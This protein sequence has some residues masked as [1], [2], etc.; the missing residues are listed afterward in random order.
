MT[1]LEQLKIQWQAKRANYSQS[2]QQTEGAILIAERRL[3]EA[4]SHL[5]DM[6]EARAAAQTGLQV[7]DEVLLDLAKHKSPEVP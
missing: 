6:H 4:K 2:L 7:V 1:P 5:R 3:R